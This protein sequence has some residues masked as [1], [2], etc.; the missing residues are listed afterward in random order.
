MNLERSQHIK[1]ILPEITTDN[2]KSNSL[3]TFQSDTLRPI[4]KFQGPTTTPSK[5][6]IVAPDPKALAPIE[7]AAAESGRKKTRLRPT[8]TR[9]MGWNSGVMSH[10]I[11]FLSSYLLVEVFRPISK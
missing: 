6:S 4:L 10:T 8:S 9:F 5:L 1:S 7:V 2:S 11:A 3:E